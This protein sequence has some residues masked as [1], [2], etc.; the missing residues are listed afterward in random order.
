MKCGDTG[1]DAFIPKPL[2]AT[3]ILETLKHLN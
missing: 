2:N 3:L 1:F